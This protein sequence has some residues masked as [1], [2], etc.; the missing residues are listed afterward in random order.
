VAVIVVVFSILITTNFGTLPIVQHVG[1]QVDTND[2]DN[3]AVTSPKIRD[4]EVRTP[5]IADEAVATD[6]IRRGAVVTESLADNSVTSDKIADGSIMIEDLST[7][8]GIGGE[9]QAVSHVIF[10]TCSIDFGPIAAQKATTALCPVPGVQVG[11]HVVATSQ[12]SSL[13]IVTQSA[14]VN[15]TELVR[16]EV[17]NPT[18]K[19]VDP[20]NITW[21]LIAFR[22]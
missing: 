15:G 6:K 22:T 13:D 3:G 20:P 14:S 16:I 8:G 18:F 1:A 11:D 10:N 4:G 19:T 21:A 2:I 17:W 5:D 9:N 7:T 12:D